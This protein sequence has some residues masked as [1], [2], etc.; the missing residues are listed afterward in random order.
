MFLVVNRLPR[1]KSPLFPAFCP[2]SAMMAGTMGLAVG[3]ATVL[4]DVL[5]NSL[6]TVVLRL[7]SWRLL[8]LAVVLG[9]RGVHRPAYC[10]RLGRSSGVGSRCDYIPRDV[11]GLVVRGLANA[12]L[13]EH[14]ADGI[15]CLEQLLMIPRERTQHGVE[16][17]PRPAVVPT[18]NEPRC[19]DSDGRK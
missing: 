1:G 17:V 8:V 12:S 3:A 10:C 11:S 7:T 15:R 6:G 13:F 18:R 4:S 5:A 2:A 19:Y 9:Y 16:V 14:A